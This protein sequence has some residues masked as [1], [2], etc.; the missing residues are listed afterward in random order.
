MH[1]RYMYVYSRREWGS[2]ARIGSAARMGVIFQIEIEV[3]GENDW[4]AS[5]DQQ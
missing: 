1:L 2:S 4:G 3:S 5:S